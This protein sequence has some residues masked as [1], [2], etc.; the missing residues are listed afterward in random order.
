MQLPTCGASDSDTDTHRQR[1]GPLLT[2]PELLALQLVA[3]GYPPEQ[4]ATLTALPLADVVGDLRRAAQALGTATLG[5][6]IAEAR[7]RGL[8]V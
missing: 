8:I 7:A 6:A 5:T 2:G 3:R 1:S 4:I